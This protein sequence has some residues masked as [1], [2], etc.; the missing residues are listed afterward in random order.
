MADDI[1]IED[2]DVEEDLS[3]DPDLRAVLDRM[4]TL[5]G[6]LSVYDLD[7]LLDRLR[8][9]NAKKVELE[10]ILK[11]ESKVFSRIKS[12]ATAV[13]KD[14]DREDYKGP[15][16][17]ISIKHIMQVKMPQ[18]PEAKAQL[19]AWMR[20]K[21]IYDRYAT[22]HAT[23]LKS[24]FDQELKIAQQDLGDDFDPIA[25]ALP[26]MEPATYFDDLKFTPAKK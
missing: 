24:L 7:F 9:K 15:G 10:K 3:N 22:V 21:Q 16:G 19:W 13:L 4:A 14:L 5:K 25:F 18:T 23:A 20:E 6:K 11:R 2:L 17:S 26:G 12:I 1:E 8:Q